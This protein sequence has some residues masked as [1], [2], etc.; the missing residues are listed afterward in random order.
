MSNFIIAAKEQPR[1]IFLDT[2]VFP[3]YGAAVS[4]LVIL[5]QV[6]LRTSPARRLYASIPA[7]DTTATQIENVENLSEQS[8]YAITRHIRQLGGPLIF[9]YRLARFLACLTLLS[10]TIFTVVDRAQHTRHVKHIAPAVWI[11]VALCGTYGYASF[12]ALLSV[13]T[14]AQLSKLATRHLALVLLLVWGVYVYRDIWPLATYSLTPVDAAEGGLLWAKFSVL[15]FAAV[16]VPLLVPRQYIPVDLTSPWKPTPEQTA[17]LLS[18]MIYA[19]LD[20]TVWEAYKVPH[21]PIE[22][23]PALADYDSATYLVRR[24]FEHLDP[25]QVKKKRHLFWSLMSVFRTEYCVL[26]L[27]LTIQS[28]TQFASPIGINQLLR[29]LEHNGEGAFVRPWVWISWLF[30]GPVLGSVA[31]QWYIFNTTRM[32]TQA[33]GIMTQLIFEHSLRIRVKAE[34]SETPASSAVNTAVGTPDNASIVEEQEHESPTGSSGEDETMF[35]STASVDT[36]STQGKQKA[37][38]ASVSGDSKKNEE[39]PANADGTKGGNLVGK[40]NNLVTTDLDNIIHGRDFL[41]IVVE[42][43]IQL[44]LCVWF[45]YSILGWSA[46]TGMAVMVLMFPLPG[47]VAKIIQSIQQEKMKKTDARV[48]DVTETMNVIRM[49]KLFGWEPRVVE[50]ILDK[51]EEELS[52]QWKYRLYG[53][54]NAILNHVIPFITMIV[55]FMT[56][57]VFMKRQLTASAVFSSMAVFDMLRQSM[58]MIFG[59]L[60]EIIRGKVSLDRVNDFLHNTELLDKFYQ[61]SSESEIILSQ[62]NA[63]NDVIGIRHSSFRWSNDE[64]GMSTPGTAP[65][66]F[67]LRIEDEVTFRRGHINLIV[68]PTGSGKTSLLMALLGEM[69]HIPSGPD[70]YFNLPREGGV[71]YAAQESWVQNETIRDNILFGAPYEEE[72]YHK[73][74]EQCGLKRDLTLFDAGDQTEVGEKGLTLSGGQKARITLARAVYSSA[75]ILL[76]DDVLAALDVHTARWVIDKCFKGDLVRGRTVLLVTHNVAMVTPI[77]EF[78]VSLGTD[79]CILSHGTLSKALEKDKELSAEVEEENKEIEKKEQEIDQVEEEAGSKKSDGKLIVA[80]EVSVGHVSWAALKMFLFSLGGSHQ[81]F[82]WF[83][84]LATLLASE[85][86]ETIQTWFLGFW[87][88]QYEEQDPSQVKVSFYLSVYALLLLGS[89]ALYCIGY[90]FYIYGALRASRFIHSTLISSVL[91]TTLRWL[92]MTPTSRI[93]TRCT[94]DIAAVDGPIT[95]YFRAVLELSISMLTKLAAVVVMSPIFL[96]PGVLVAVVGGWCGQVYMKAQLSVKREMSNARAPVLGHFGA[97]IAG[98]TS[99]RAYDAQ[100]M[101]RKESYSRINRWICI[102]IDT[103]GALFSAGLAT[104]LVYGGIFTASNTGFSLNMAVGFSGM[105]LWWVRVLNEFEVSGNSL[106][107]I[108][109]YASI[110]QE[111]EPSEQ[112]VPPAYWPSSGNLRVENLSARYSLDGPRVLHDISFEIKSGERVGIVGRTG[113]GKSSLT[114]SLLRCIITEGK[115]YYDG[116]ATDTIN[117]DA[118]RSSITIIPQVPEL[119]SGTLRQNLDPFDQHDDAV[120]NDALQAAGLFSLQSDTEEGRIT[121]DSQISSGGGNLSVGQRQILALA[122]AIV[123]QSKLLILDEATSAIDYATDTIIQSSLRR[124][125]DQGVTLLTIAHRLQTIMDADKIMVLDAGRVVEFGKPSELL[126]NEKGMLRALVDESGDKEALYAMAE[127]GSTSA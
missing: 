104:Y 6:I 127:G 119:L 92:D 47:Y 108:E 80:E 49:V 65:R 103:L 12:L 32:L 120:L 7:S 100:E 74:I 95:D 84:C 17:C 9:A 38:A 19:W 34:V 23:L 87:A 37:K 85:L 60:P 15:S 21:L 70:S 3:A 105:I 83:L 111:P 48:Q 110:E 86:T 2:L 109:Q 63:P 11:Q 4:V 96:I 61:G 25:F 14:N 123:R 82:F 51:R 77:A 45:L 5:V 40:I 106:E 102:R 28:F 26:A 115:V 53:M 88:R 122:R 90:I 13:A 43:P 81:F 10:M 117:L 79:G 30:F 94:Q 20:R 75:E 31:V 97:A 107:R 91:G 54:I 44:C 8:S 114:L 98:L 62:N 68:G 24:S 113:S 69:H 33:T 64:D 42:I 101:F 58:H 93:I 46:F 55:T 35:A 125:L 112:G 72:R 99:I 18:M 29:Y 52:Y 116:L 71:A 118:L 16:F 89:S 36:S 56:Y 50:K 73:V 76:L 57:T 121:L 1:T 124:E 22:K 41:F 66:N 59:L 27:M 67:I 39:K 126:K 78:V